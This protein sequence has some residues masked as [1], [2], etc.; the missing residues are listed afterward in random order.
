MLPPGSRDARS[1]RS[2][3]NRRPRAPHLAERPL[4]GT[5]EGPPVRRTDGREHGLD[6]GHA[7]ARRHA[8]RRT[9]RRPPA[10]QT[11]YF[12]GG[13]WEYRR[14]LE[15]TGDDTD[16]GGARVRG[17]L[18][19]R[20]GLGERRAR[21]AP[22]LRLL[23]LLRAR[24][25]TCCGTATRTRSRSRPARTRTP[26]GTPA[27]A[28]TGTYGSCVGGR[29]TSR[30]TAC[31]VRT[32]E[33]DDDGAVVAVATVVRNE[34]G[35]TSTADA[36]RRD[37]STPTARSSLATDAPVTT[38]PGDTVTARQRL[39]VADPALEPRRPD[40]YT[41]RVAVLDGD[42]VARRRVDDV[43]HP[44]ARGRSA[45]RGLRINGEPVAPARRVRPPRQ[46]RRSARRRSTAPTSAGSSCS[47][48]RASTR[49]RS[50]HNP[51]STAMLD[52]CDRLGMLVMDETFDMW[53][54][55]KTDDDYALR[56]PDWWEA[57]VEAMVRK[58]RQ[59]P[60]R[61]PLLHRQRDP[62]RLDARRAARRARARREGPRARRHP[63]RHQRGQP[64]CSSAGPSCSI[65]IAR[66]RGRDRDRR[67]DRRQHD[68]H[69][70]WSDL[71]DHAMQSPVVDRARPPRRTPTS[72]SRGYNYIESRFEIDRELLPATG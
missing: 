2:A 64:A 68:D 46:R 69:E 20:D 62:R 7:A 14:T 28:S 70:R 43:R 3:L 36:A 26:A 72:T 51:M 16:D 50:A 61:D 25:T 9:D 5:P 34:S 55:P 48:R 13:S 37:R 11:G 42:D 29:C 22:A 27:P 66:R 58:D 19:R 4:V 1:H 23:E 44:H 12:P 31:D 52:A 8:R 10:P 35:A 47:R 38:F 33:I 32:P 59:P 56:F 6:A 71:M 30:P 15:V 63:L 41:C 65:D 57:D 24:S 67:G 54:E 18:P 60:V 21:R 49:I 45:E 40:L 39:L 17:R 53:T